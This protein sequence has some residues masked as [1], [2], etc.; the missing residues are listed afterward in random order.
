MDYPHKK[1]TTHR[2]NVLVCSTAIHRFCLSGWTFCTFLKNGKGI[3]GGY[4]SIEYPLLYNTLLNFRDL[5]GYLRS[6]DIK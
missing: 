2:T 3:V 5:I 6:H 1:R 4:F